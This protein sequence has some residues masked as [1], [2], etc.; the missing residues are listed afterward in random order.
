M[1][2]WI[3]VLFCTLIFSG[4]SE[5][6][7][8]TASPELSESDE[9]I[10]LAFKNETSNLQVQGTGIVIK[11]LSDDDVGSRHQRFILQLSSR[12]TLLISHNIDL[13]A[14][15]DTLQLNDTVEFYG[16]Y[17]WNSQG[18]VVHWTH[19]DPQKAHEDGW[20][21]HNQIIYH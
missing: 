11:L 18:G 1:K 3:L 2:N 15:I 19:D 7:T 4:C 20:L 14:R 17:E 5:D 13:A 21:K 16:E 10:F 6:Q 9:I 8:E 12:Q